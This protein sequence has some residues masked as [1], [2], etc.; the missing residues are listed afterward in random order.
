MF[1]SMQDRRHVLECPLMTCHLPE[2]VVPTAAPCKMLC[3]SLPRSHTLCMPQEA[4]C[5]RLLQ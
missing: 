1:L 5:K 3:A 2:I 4:G